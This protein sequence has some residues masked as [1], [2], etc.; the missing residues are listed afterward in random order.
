MELAQQSR[1]TQFGDW[2]RDEDTN[3]QVRTLTYIDTQIFEREISRIFESSWVY[4]GHTS[5]IP[6]PGDYKTAWLGRVPVILAR[7]KSQA[8]HVFSNA[9]RHR[10]MAVCRDAGGNTSAFRCP[11]HG[12]T[13]AL[14][15]TLLG[16]TDRKGYQKDFPKQ[17]DGLITAQGVEVYRGLIFCSLKK[18]PMPLI[19]HLG[20]VRPYVDAWADA[21]IGAAH[22]LHEPHRFEYPGNWK[23]QLENSVDGYHPKYVHESGFK[24][25][26]YTATTNDHENGHGAI[27]EMRDLDQNFRIEQGRT[28]SLP[29]GHS[30][31]EKRLQDMSNSENVI[32]FTKFTS[33]SYQNY[34]DALVEVYGTSRADEVSANRHIVVFPN[35]ILMDTNVRAVYPLAVDKTEVHSH[36]AEVRGVSPLVNRERLADLQQRLGTT[37]LVGP[38]DQEVFAANQAGMVAGLP[39]WIYLSRGIGMEQLLSTGERIG[40]YSSE[41]PQRAFWRQWAVSMEEV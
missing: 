30:V 3:F 7:D 26:S 18:P 23:Y 31:L 9:C 33:P 35:L 41:T 29:G 14:D 1:R 2:L 34:R 22:R 4:I 39:E 25:L 20:A 40:D 37:G 6:E 10:G 32:G 27:R 17:I 8:I 36:F 38:D 19:D 28:R 12:W 13:Y 21:S 5:E 24:A 15:G 16:V 11:Y